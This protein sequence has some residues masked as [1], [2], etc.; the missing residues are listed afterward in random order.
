LLREQSAIGVIS[1]PS[2][3]QDFV[4]DLTVR[5]IIRLTMPLLPGTKLDGYE[6]LGLLGAGGM[7][8]VYRARD[9]VLKREVAIKVLPSFVSQDPD[10]LRRFEQEAQAAAAL[11]HPNI[12][13]VHRFGVF[14][15]VPYLVS[16]LLVGETLRQQLERGPLPARKAI[17]YAVQIAHGLAAAHD[18]GIVHRDLKPENLFVTKDGR[19]KIL[20]FGLAKLAQRQTELDGS[21][22]TMMPGTDPGLVMGTVGYMAPEQVRGRPVDHRADI[23]AFGAI[24]YEML[25]GKRAFQRSTSAE[26]MTAILNED[27]PIISQIVQSIPPGLQ[28]VVHRCLEKSPEQRFQS[29]SD[30]A[31]ALE[32]LSDSGI[33]SA[34]AIEAPGQHWRGK[35]LRWSTA[36][37]TV[38]G[39]VAV[40]YYFVMRRE[41]VPFEHYSIQKVIDS[42]HVNTIAISPDGNYLAAVVS[43]ANGVQSILIHHIPTNSERSLVQDPAFHNYHDV[44][45]SP[46][47]SYIYFRI[48]SVIKPSYQSDVYRIPVLGGKATLVIEDVDFP[49]SFVDGGQRVCFF[50]GDISGS[51]KFLTA[52]ADGG[53]EH[54]LANGNKPFPN[55]IACA[56][57]GKSAVLA[58]I[59]GKVESL[60]FASGSKRTLSPFTGPGGYL[61]DMLWAPDGKGL[62]TTN[63]N[64][65]HPIYQ[66]S[67]LAYPSGDLRH[68]TNDLSDYS[69]VSLTSDGKTLATTQ[70][71]DN[72]RFGELSLA[73]PTHVQEH[74]TGGRWWFTWLDDDRILAFDVVRGP[75]LVDLRKDEITSL[76]V[77][78]GH[79]FNRPAPCGPDTLVLIG[80]TLD[81]DSRSIYKMH[82]DGSGLTQLTKG[83]YD[84]SPKCTSDG[85]WLFFIAVEDGNLGVLMRQGA[86]GGAVRIAVPPI[87]GYDLSPAGDLLLYATPEGTHAQAHV[88]LTESLREI[89]SFPLPRNINTFVAL[90]ADSKSV[91]YAAMTGVDSIIWRQ[92]LDASAPLKVANLSGKYVNWVSPSPDGKKLG[93]ILET[94]TSEAVLLRETR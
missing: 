19:I 67:F 70:E 35:V 80:G 53:D 28:R 66:I 87:Y 42:E 39:L 63:W 86:Q 62:F 64:T 40:A 5:G 92:P 20:D 54:V 22:P 9:P 6:V 21:E 94:P 84:G 76:N 33:S 25:S 52:S 77:P 45:F 69:G 16:E 14:D 43:D 60:D 24:L 91:F 90:S 1:K 78:K 18:K 7:G 73:D 13:A 30:L 32:A 72:E 34:V 74:Q 68:I 81:G 27:P 89:K 29:P 57:N 65:P 82:L 55:S 3:N 41:R 75:S 8:E 38:L 26:T 46:D 50:R 15:G 17:D 49:F 23:F 85:K 51:Y 88:V 44:I 79:W 58:D 2:T 59:R 4:K 36:L 37:L 48:E 61:S 10:R 12:L 31:F 56:P 71:H 47:G 83:P 11:N 93:L